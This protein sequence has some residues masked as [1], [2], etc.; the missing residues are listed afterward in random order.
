MLKNKVLQSTIGLGLAFLALTAC[1]AQN[2][3][4]D[5]P[6]ND[7]VTA[8]EEEPSQAAEVETPEKADEIPPAQENN[9]PVLAWFGYVSGS[10]NPEF[11]NKLVLMPE[12]S[13]EI[14]LR[15]STAKLEKEIDALRYQEEP[16]K[17]AHFWGSLIC[18]EN[19]S[20]NCHL[21]VS[22][23]RYGANA[24]DPEPIQA[25]EGSLST[26]SF[27]S[28]DSIV[29]TLNGTYPIQY[30]VHSYD[31][32]I[33]AQ[34]ESLRQSVNLVR[35]SGDLLTGISDVNGSRIQVNQIEVLQGNS[36]AGPQAAAAQVNPAADWQTYASKAHLY[37]LSYPS[38]AV[39]HQ[40]EIV[41]FPSD[42]LPE[43]K[44]PDEYMQQL[45]QELGDGLCLYL[46][47]GLSYLYL[48]APA[49]QGFNYVNCTLRNFPPEGEVSSSTQEILIEG[50]ACTAS[51]SEVRG[52]N[53]TLE[54][55][56]EVLRLML[57]DGTLFEFGSLP[58]S[59]ASF[60]DY[61]MKGRDSIL[62]IVST[63]TSLK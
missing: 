26:A 59:D 44:T 46:E 15:G 61:Q 34:L 12:G 5:A 50:K 55:H 33:L 53:D 16:G 57:E 49:N 10:A 41:K 60:E 27:N 48:S 32:D 25:W 19:E 62:Q 45:R 20:R 2:N 8:V 28:G 43:G 30:S 21:Q 38:G 22:R 31:A 3:Q 18:A 39:L 52:E 35:I 23:L 63:Y 6:I 56:Y 24:T 47:N 58:R 29:F 51:V 4:L 7:T 13:G 37:S 9:M 42:E 40:E 17:Y 14:N 1:S 54:E 36:D 11:T